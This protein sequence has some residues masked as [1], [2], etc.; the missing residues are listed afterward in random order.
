[1]WSFPCYCDEVFFRF[2][3]GLKI[4]APEFEDFRKHLVDGEHLEFIQPVLD[5][6]RDAVVCMVGHDIG[7]VLE[8]LQV[9]NL[10]GGTIIRVA[11]V[12]RLKT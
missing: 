12:G 8:N 9:L 11:F 10:E 2:D 3:F 1:M 5:G 4:H 6:G 7:H